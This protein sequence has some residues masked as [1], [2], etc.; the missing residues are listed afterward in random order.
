MLIAC[1]SCRRQYNVEGM[2]VGEHVRCRCGSL[3]EVP[4]ARPREARRLHC[5]GCGGKLQTAARVCGY[6]GSEIL[7]ADRNLGPAC[8]EC[9][10]RLATGARFCNDCGIEIRTDA[11]RATRA[12]ANCPRCAGHLA[13]IEIPSGHYTECTACGG[14]WLDAT[15]FERI[16]EKRDT[17][18]LAPFISFASGKEDVEVPPQV[19][20]YLSCPTCGTLMHRKNFGCGSGILI[21]WCKGHGFWFDTQELEKVLQ[22]ISAGGLDRARKHEIE[23]TRHEIQRLQEEKRAQARRGGGFQ[24]ES[25]PRVDWTGGLLDVGSLI[26]RL[27]K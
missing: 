4:R 13:L 7:A 22:F 3:V 9:F 6:C 25:L 15:S 21:D 14:I 18:S 8:P 5:S 11:I 26:W 17:T 24:V 23:R 12:K 1:K 10:S 27:F 2:Q 20:K 19:V 16:V